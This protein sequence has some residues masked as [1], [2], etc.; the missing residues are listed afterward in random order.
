MQTPT[1]TKL[2]E[3]RDVLELLRAGRLERATELLVHR[4]R[5]RVYNYCAT[6]LRDA[7][8]AEDVCQ[9]VFLAVRKDLETYADHAPLR[10]WLFA[11]ARHRVVDDARA[12]AR[13]RHRLLREST[14][15][16]ESSKDPRDDLNSRLDEL[17]MQ[18]ALLA[19]MRELAPSTRRAIEL[20]FYDG[21]SFEEMAARCGEKAG[22]LQARVSRA[23]SKL[24]LQ[25]RNESAMSGKSVQRISHDLFR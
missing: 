13:R 8:R 16:G 17:R 15:R 5:K 12:E 19:A 10:S 22:T 2:T 4:Y 7:A 25:V 20:R 24:Q 11:I 23:L 1:Q 14:Y 3:D 9:Q 21:L 18:T 6:A